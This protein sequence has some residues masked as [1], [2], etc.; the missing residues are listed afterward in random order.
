LNDERFI[1]SVFLEDFTVNL[2]RFTL[3]SFRTTEFLS[4]TT[5]SETVT[6]PAATTLILPVGSLAN[7][8]VLPSLSSHL[9]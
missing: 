4:V 3:V 7:P 5:E 8:A 9:R 1:P 6:D 2:A